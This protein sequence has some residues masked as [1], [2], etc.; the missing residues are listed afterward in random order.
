M[1]QD[2]TKDP[3]TEIEER[4]W[5]AFEADPQITATVRPGNRSKFVGEDTD[6]DPWRRSRM[7]GD[8]PEL[9]VLVQDGQVALASSSSY[10]GTF[11]WEAGLA[12]ETLQADI[13]LYPT[14]W[15]M[16]RA[17]LRSTSGISALPYV[18]QVR[19]AGVRA[20]Q[21][22]LDPSIQEP[23][24]WYAAVLVSVDV[25]FNRD[26]FDAPDKGPRQE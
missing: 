20:G 12:T 8:L 21:R 3:L 26:A 22:G 2:L 13:N 7:S 19:I 15:A 9:L 18:K 14:A 24:G 23:R 5:A 6:R 16:L 10:R 4:I 1:T 17:A 11:V 25:F